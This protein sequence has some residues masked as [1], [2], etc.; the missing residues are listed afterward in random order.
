MTN[1]ITNLQE[2]NKELS[3]KIADLEKQLTD[4]EENFKLRT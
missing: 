1:I 2:R 3:D 4:K